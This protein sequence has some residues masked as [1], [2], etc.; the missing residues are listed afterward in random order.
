MDTK[1]SLTIRV[2]IFIVVG[3]LLLLGLSLRVE[4]NLFGRPVGVNLLAKFKD[5]KGLETGAPVMLGGIDIGEVEGLNFDAREA[6]V[7]AKLFIRS[8]YHLKKDS[9]A[10]IRLQSLLG[11]YYISVDFGNP[12][13]PD[14]QYGEI[15]QTVETTDVTNALQVIGDVGHEIK[16][17][18]SNFNKNQQKL[19]DQITSLI[20][21]NRENIK[22]TTDSFAEIAP[23]L[24]EIVKKVK[25]GEGTV[26]R[27]FTDDSLYR[28]LTSAADGVSSLTL[29][30][31]TGKG[32]L[33]RLIYSDELVTRAE[34]TFTDVGKAAE[35]INTIVTDNKESINKF[36]T[37][38]GDVS[39]KLQSAVDSISQISKKVNEGE[40]TLGKLVNDPSL[41]KN[42][43][44]AVNQIKAQFEEAEEQSVVRTFLSIVF[45]PVM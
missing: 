9:V 5:V 2:G 4:K 27:L 28:Q 14:L 13:T 40:G 31:R 34:Q 19:T 6:L 43:N 26:G 20:D 38:L 3:C 41:Y 45:G 39:P 23:I 17:L 35:N 8:P 44:T 7:E 32:T 22:K 10:S 12:A 29:D 33:S 21:E 18:A 36:L 30:V 42:T 11:Q 15:I 1:S 37:S 16:D 24:T 25:K